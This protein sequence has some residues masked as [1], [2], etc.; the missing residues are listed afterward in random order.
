MATDTRLQDAFPRPFSTNNREQ[1]RIT[2][3]EVSITNT[4]P[5]SIT[6][7]TRGHQRI[8]VPWGIFHPEPNA[9]DDRMRIIH[10]SPDKQPISSLQVVDHVTGK[11]IRGDEQ[12]GIESLTDSRIS[13]RP[14]PED[15]A[16]LKPGEPVLRELD[17]GTLVDGQ[18]KIR[19]QPKGCR[20]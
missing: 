17:I 7:Q 19:M 4:G 5:D 3:L 15:V 12:R 11:V 2:F 16:T 18:Y 9:D 14:R 13:R 8:L 1:R 10:T 6:V 20:W